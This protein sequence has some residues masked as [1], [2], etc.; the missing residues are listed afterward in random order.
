MRSR[1]RRCVITGLTTAA[2]CLLVAPHAAAVPPSVRGGLGDDFLWGVAASGFQSEGA[3]PDNNWTRYIEAK[4][5]EPYEQSV[6][7]Y[8]RYASDIALAAHLGARVFRIGIE[9]AR[10]Q[11]QPGQWDEEAFRFYDAVVAEIL[12]HGMR[13]MLTLD[14]WVYPGWVA[15]RGGWNDPAIVED[16]LRNARR[17][18]DRYADWNPVWVTVNE[19]VAYI[20]HEVRHNGT[21]AG[22]M[23]DLVARAHNDIYDYIHRVQPDARVTSNVGYVA[24]AEAEVNGPLLDRIGAK[25]D[26]I[27]V[28]Y[29]F[30]LQA[31]EAS[32]DGSVPPPAG[33]WEL[34]VRPEGIYYALRHYAERFPDKPLY[35][36]ENG[37]PTED[38]AP[39]A[40]GYTRSDHLRDTVYWIQR[41]RADGMNVIGYNYWSITD[42]YEWGSYAPRFGLYTV[43]VRTDPNL[44]RTP[45]DAV[46]TYRDIIAA[47][48][49]PAEYRPVR[50]LSDCAL[51][52]PP[53]SC[54]HP[55]T[56][57]EVEFAGQTAS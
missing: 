44:T 28:D 46:D 1:L 50:P 3:T 57:P 16:W 49:V 33:M 18:V 2:A 4:G 5:Y 54:E 27:G 25:L 38:G 39:R 21:D 53:A 29:Y 47:D 48:G 6:D 17:V 37:M 26:I 56:V 14:H 8:H 20:M 22:R 43:D 10:V 35:I 30:G 24:G 13:P 32:T 40:D 42:N 15:D 11:P 55:V 12:D 36:V 9:W 34:P 23:L 51:V 19:P 52:D 7:F 41:A 31:P 45:T